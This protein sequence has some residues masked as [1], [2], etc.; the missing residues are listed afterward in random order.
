MN[1]ETLFKIKNYN[2]KGHIHE[3]KLEWLCET[4]HSLYERHNGN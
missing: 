2:F 3:L 1:P 4:Y